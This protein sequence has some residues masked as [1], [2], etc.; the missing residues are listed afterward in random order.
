MKGFI[1]GREYKAMRVSVVLKFKMPKGKD[2]LKT[3]AYNI[4]LKQGILQFNAKR[5]CID[6]DDTSDTSEEKQ[7]TLTAV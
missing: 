2:N 7:P 3:Y 5:I 1:Y 6:Q 4:C